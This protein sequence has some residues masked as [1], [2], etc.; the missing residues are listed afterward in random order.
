VQRLLLLRH[1]KVKTLHFA[2]TSKGS[3]GLRGRRRRRLKEVGEGMEKGSGNGSGA[4][5]PRGR[6]FKWRQRRH[7]ALFSRPL[8]R[9]RIAAIFQALAE[10]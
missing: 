6:N 9:R 5:I 4:S 7:T 3:K 2:L 8:L 10:R 1:P